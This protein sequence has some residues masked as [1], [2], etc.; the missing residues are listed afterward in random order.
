MQTWS[1]P[2]LVCSLCIVPFSL[3]PRTAILLTA[4]IVNPCVQRSFISQRYNKEFL[5]KCYMQ[6]FK[7]QHQTFKSGVCLYVGIPIW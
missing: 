1:T 6:S 2:L 5:E 4:H 3:Q 7:K